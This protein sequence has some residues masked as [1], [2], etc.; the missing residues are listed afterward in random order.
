MCLRGRTVPFVR[1]SVFSVGWNV[2]RVNTSADFFMI[3][4]LSLFSAELYIDLAGCRRCRRRCCFFI[5]LFQPVCLPFFVCFFSQSASGGLSP[6]RNVLK[7]SCWFHF[8]I[9]QKE[10]NNQTTGSP[11]PVTSRSPYVKTPQKGKK[12]EREVL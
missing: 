3:L 7:L 9:A 2:H 4:L 6:S 8:I 10:K 5:R 1:A 11:R 12:R